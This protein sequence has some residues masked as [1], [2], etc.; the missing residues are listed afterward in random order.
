MLNAPI[1]ILSAV[2][3]R[4]CDEGA[5]REERNPVEGELHG[6]NLKMCLRQKPSFLRLLRWIKHST[7]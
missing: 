4:K 5:Q 1:G 6:W 7:S 2:T 3:R